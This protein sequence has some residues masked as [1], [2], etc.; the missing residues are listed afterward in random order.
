M[1]LYFTLTLGS[2]EYCRTVLG[3]RV[4]GLVSV[5]VIEATVYK[6]REGQCSTFYLTQW[7]HLDECVCVCVCGLILQQA[8]S[9]SSLLNPSQQPFVLPPSSSLSPTALPPDPP[10]PRCCCWTSG[11]FSPAKTNRVIT[12]A[13]KNKQRCS[14]TLNPLNLFKH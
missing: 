3:L 2:I 12:V 11:Q 10:C 5:T 9:P 7:Y 1:W 4:R 8:R 13:E 14:L 6:Q